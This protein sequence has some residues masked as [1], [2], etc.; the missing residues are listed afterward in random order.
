VNPATAA[1][2]YANIP[3]YSGLNAQSSANIGSQLRGEL[4]TD[5]VNQIAQRAAERGVVSGQTSPAAY[6][7]ALGL[8]SLQL[9][10]QGETALNASV[11]RNTK[12]P[13][14]APAM[15]FVSPDE[16]QSAQ[17][18]ANIYASAPNPGAAQA[19]QMNAARSG[20]NSGYNGSRAP[21]NAFASYGMPQQN[22]FS[23]ALKS[24]VQQFA[25]HIDSQQSAPV[26]QASPPAFYPNL[27]YGPSNESYDY[28]TTDIPPSS[29]GSDYSLPF[30]E[31]GDF[32]PGE[33]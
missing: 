18:A 19:A 16:V 33:Y 11:G 14:Y 2:Y 27:Y 21:L 13:F 17:T 6:L 29:G 24:I 3:N 4:P 10:Q 26:T 32:Y 20:M 22:D 15:G 1:Q 30:P 9:Q 8:N 31:S 28:L 7:S 25:P 5:V 23:D 12:A